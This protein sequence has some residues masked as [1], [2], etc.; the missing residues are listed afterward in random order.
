MK[1]FSI[2]DRC[3]AFFPSDELWYDATVDDKIRTTDNK[4][5][6][7][8]TYTGYNHQRTVFKWTLPFFLPQACGL[9]FW[10]MLFPCLHFLLLFTANVGNV[11]HNTTTNKKKRSLSGS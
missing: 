4:D 10:F 6:Y 9:D 7:R 5:A 8:V 2:G 3:L 11:T 1:I